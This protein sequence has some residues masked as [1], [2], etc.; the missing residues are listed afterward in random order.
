MSDKYKDSADGHQGTASVKHIN[1]D[2]PTEVLVSRLN[3]LAHSV[4]LGPDA[5]RQEFNMHIPTELDHAVDWILSGAAKELERLQRQNA[6]YEKSLNTVYELKD[7]YSQE[8]QM[9]AAEVL[10]RIKNLGGDV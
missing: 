6:A 8:Y 5:V 1:D 3:E 9:I 4:T 2:V 10:D 7:G